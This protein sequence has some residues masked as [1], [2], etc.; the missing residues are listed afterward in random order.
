MTELAT[1]TMSNLPASQIE[2]TIATYTGDLR[3]LGVE[4]FKMDNKSKHAFVAVVKRIE[5]EAESRGEKVSKVRDG[6]LKYVFGEGAST[7]RYYTW[8]KAY[9]VIETLSDEVKEKVFRYG[10]D[11]FGVTNLQTLSAINN[12]RTKVGE[13]PLSS[14]EIEKAMDKAV[15]EGLNTTD[16][17]AMLK[18][19]YLPKQEGEKSETVPNFDDMNF[20]SDKPVLVAVKFEQN[21]LNILQQWFNIDTLSDDPKERGEQ[22]YREIQSHMLKLQ[23]GGE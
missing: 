1:I 21:D 2:Q 3:E 14:D 17:T 8:E 22:L 11:G 6:Y 23:S 4:L 5:A 18:D 19:T 10:A 20:P 9:R 7:G 15:D 13:E 16:T 12:A